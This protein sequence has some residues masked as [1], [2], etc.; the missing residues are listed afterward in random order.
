[1]PI[2]NAIQPPNEFYTY[3]FVAGNESSFNYDPS[4]LLLTTTGV[5]GL[6][7]NPMVIP[8][9]QTIV[10]LEFTY[11]E[12][13]IVESKNPDA[14][15]YQVSLT[16]YEWY[17]YN[18]ATLAWTRTPVNATITDTMSASAFAEQLPNF[19]WEIG[20]GSLQIKM[21][22]TD[23][24]PDISGMIIFFKK[25]YGNIQEIKKAMAQYQLIRRNLVTKL[26]EDFVNFDIVKE[27]LRDADDFINSECQ[28][29]FYY[30]QGQREW[31]NGTATNKLVTRWFPILNIHYLVMY[32]QL[33]QAMRTFLDSEMILGQGG[34]FGE[35]FL[36]PIYPAYLTDHPVKSLFGNVFIPGDQ[37]IEILYD[38]GYRK[39]PED[40]KLASKK[41]MIMYLLQDYIVFITRGANSRSI[42][43]YSESWG[44]T[45][46]FDNVIEQYRKEVTNMLARRKRYYA[47]FV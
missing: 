9:L 42:D 11:V 45:T 37:N 7:T 13:V 12:R 18:E 46:P 19:S 47:R 38:W 24:N 44:K 31:H 41:I 36:P 14:I 26:P 29:D 5:S 40:V 32:N 1:M 10:P 28:Q 25:H 43:G 6:N 17:Y 33:L 21:Y 23:L 35:I 20:D 4:L 27:K 30:H 22:F 39:T 3:D 8:T 16:G 15:R 2:D 34:A